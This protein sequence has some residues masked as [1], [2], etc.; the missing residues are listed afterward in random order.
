M[1]AINFPH[2][3]VNK[4]L[5]Q[6]FEAGLQAADPALAIRRTLKRKN[7]AL[8]VRKQ[9]YSLK[10]FKRIM[11]VGA[12]KASG[13]MAQA[14]ERQLGNKVVD[15]MVVV[16]DGHGCS[17]ATIQVHEARHPIPDKRGEYAARSILTF[18]QSLEPEDLLIVLV[19]GG[20]SSLLPLPARGVSLSDKQATTNLLLRSGATIQEINTVRKHLSA[21]KGGQLAAST[22][23]TVIGLIM[24]DVLG[25]ELGVIGSGLTASDPTTFSDAQ[26]ILQ[27]YHLW[28]TVPSSVRTRIREGAR[29]KIVET[30][31]S[32]APIFTRVQNEIIGNNELAIAN[33]A[34]KAKQLGF[35]SLVLTTMLQ[36]EAAEGGRFLGAVA[37]KVYHSGRPVARPACLIVGGEPTVTMT[38]KRRG[39]RVQELVLST[40]QAIAGLPAVYVAGIGTDG[41]DGSTDMAGAVADGQ[42]MNRAQKLGLNP[43]QALFEHD[44]YQFFCKAGGHIVTGPTGTNVNDLYV[45][46]VL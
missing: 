43:A 37:Q 31:K 32:N 11:V 40:A 45:L 30:P 29:G 16:K 9:R 36:G 20:A 8:W 17:T 5:K 46:L 34:Q 39:G 28:S 7:E 41:T 15:G 22:Q 24:S 6:L 1:V 2:K 26:Y 27:Q 10:R 19:S 38:G 3:S 44:S 42:T 25:D 13:R 4:F 14:V 35:R 12:G 18:V 21:I 33:V 23:A